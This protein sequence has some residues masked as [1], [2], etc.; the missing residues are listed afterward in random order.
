MIVQLLGGQGG[1]KNADVDADAW[2]GRRLPVERWGLLE[3]ALR[4]PVGVGNAPGI[5]VRWWHTGVE[6]EKHCAAVGGGRRFLYRRT[7]HE[8]ELYAAGEEKDF[9]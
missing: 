5:E 2:R 7:S 4:L 6:E 8:H 3:N 9:H 1:G